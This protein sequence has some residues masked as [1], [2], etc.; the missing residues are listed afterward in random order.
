YKTTQCY[1]NCQCAHPDLQTFPTRRSSDLHL[2]SVTNV[3]ENNTYSLAVIER[4]ISPSDASI[5]DALRTA[6]TFANDLSGV[7]SFVKR[8]G[9]SEEHT[10][11]LQS[12]EN[13][14]C[15]LLLEIEQITI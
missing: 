12:R 1:Y 3:K 2:I 8:A 9:R 7:D 14:V 4:E 6:Q 13:L 15:R 5:N 11:E 10:S